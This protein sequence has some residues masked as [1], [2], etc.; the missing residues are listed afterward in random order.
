MFLRRHFLLL[1]IAPMI[2]RKV[3]F[4]FSWQPLLEKLILSSNMLI[5]SPNYWIPEKLSKKAGIYLLKVNKRNTRTRCEMCSK[6]IIKI[7]ERL[8][9]LLLTFV[10]YSNANAERNNGSKCSENR[11]FEFFLPLVIYLSG[12]HLLNMSYFS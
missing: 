3:F 4:L 12:F 9:F 6:L 7:P 8:V 2:I 5:I 11:F 1:A 10:F